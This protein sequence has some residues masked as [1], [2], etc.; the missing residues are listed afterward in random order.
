M[1][2]RLRHS[3]LKQVLCLC[4]RGTTLTGIKQEFEHQ[5]KKLRVVICEE[6]GYSQDP[7]H[8]GEARKKYCIDVL[9]VTKADVVNYLQEVL[10]I[11][12]MVVAGDSGNDKDM[13]TGAGDLAIRVGGAKKN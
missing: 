9:P 7:T 6:I 4:I 13:L 12:A 3:L 10:G 1:D 5:F 11:D 8:V 2:N